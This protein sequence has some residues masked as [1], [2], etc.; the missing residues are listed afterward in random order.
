MTI[1]SNAI[2][3]DA[4][5]N[6][7]GFALGFKDFGV[8]GRNLPQAIA[9][10]SPVSTAKQSLITGN[11][12][13]EFTDA[14]SVLNQLGMC[15]AFQMMRILRP[16]SG[17]G[18]GTIKTHVFPILDAV[19]AG[20]S[21]GSIAVTMTKATK[22][23]THNVKFNGRA[24]IDGKN[25][26]FVVNK[27]DNENVVLAAIAAA[28]NGNIY[29]PVSAV[30]SAAI[31]PTAGTN[32]GTTGVLVNSLAVGLTGTDYRIKF[33][34][35]GV[36][37]E[38][39][40][41]NLSAVV[42]AAGI[43]A[44]VNTAFR[45]AGIDATMS[46]SVNDQAVITSN[47]LGI[48]STVTATSTPSAGT[49]LGLALELDSGN[50]TIVDGTA[51]TPGSIALTSKWKGITANEIFVEVDDNDDAAGLVYTVVQPNGAAGEN[52]VSDALAEFGDQ[53]Y[54][55]VLNPFNDAALD[56]LATFNGIPDPNTGG[57][58]RWAATITKPFVALYGSTETDKDDI[59]TIPDARTT[60][61]TNA[62]CPAP[63]SYGYTWEAAANMGY[64]FGIQMNNNPH[65]CIMDKYYPDMPVF[66]SD[67]DFKDYINRDF[68]VKKGVST[69][70]IKDGKYQIKD[71]ITHR[72]PS[73]QPDTAIDWRYPRDIVGVDFNVIYR[74]RILEDRDLKN[75]T[76]IN[77]NEYARV[78]DTIKPKEWKAVL[79]GYFDQ[80]VLD[81]LINDAA[82]AKESLQVAVSGT[83][84]KRFETLFNYKRSGFVAISSTTAFAGF[85]YGE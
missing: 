50:A 68:M 59:T 10:L 38:T 21:S 35:D 54:T 72:H 79:F 47:S 23:T 5:S 46:V 78:Q 11:V 12:P 18:V 71:F 7:T 44:A 16:F 80:L 30:V 26:S 31:L 25:F 82:F 75:K 69:A 34:L 24:S 4:V 28:I 14:K 70:V 62:L 15:P 48:S 77:D 55:I 8:S 43:V 84:P 33:T 67:G 20:A 9:I 64:V 36:S 61:L 29:S 19:G 45:V 17:G 83:N 39:G 13:I 37:V 2:S 27:D 40:D 73:D 60:D 81:A 65:L 22:S 53:W 51:G 66:A 57:T 63:G 41:I 52:A 74:Y 6:V 32:S 49:D 3:Q 76:L 56:D 85:N 1:L 58:G 42:T